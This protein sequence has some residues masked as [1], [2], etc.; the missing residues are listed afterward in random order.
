R[1]TGLPQRGVDAEDHTLPDLDGV[2]L[3]PAGLRKVLRELAIG[4]ADQRAVG[5]EHDR[6]AARRALIDRQE[7]PRHGVPTLVLRILWCKAAT[8]TRQQGS[9]RRAASCKPAY[10]S[11]SRASSSAR[12]AGPSPTTSSASAT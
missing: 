10:R 6:P 9:P 3:D 12:R 1:H 2:V 8:A 11:R 7:V 5:T 4:L